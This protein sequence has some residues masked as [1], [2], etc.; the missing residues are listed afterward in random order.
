MP[1]RGIAAECHKE[2][3]RERSSRMPQRKREVA[4]CHREEIER[5]DSKRLTLVLERRLT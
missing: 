5:R 2:R 4:E 1:Q 3:Q